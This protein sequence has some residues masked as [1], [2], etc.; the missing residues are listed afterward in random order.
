ML[1]HGCPAGPR[2][3][4][5]SP[6]V[7]GKGGFAPLYSLFLLIVCTA[8]SAV[9]RS[10]FLCAS[11]TAGEAGR[12]ETPTA[13]LNFSWTSDT[14]EKWEGEL[15]L[16][17]GT[18]TG[19]APLG[20]DRCASVTFYPSEDRKVISISSPEPTAFC[21]A[22]VT[23]AAV[24][25][26][27]LSL[28]FR[29]A[30]GTNSF[31]RTFLLADVSESA[32]RVPL[33]D[34]GHDLVI[35]RAPGD[36]IP[37]SVQ[38]LDRD[39]VPLLPASPSMVFQQGETL[40]I[41]IPV[42]RLPEGAERYEFLA[43]LR[44]TGEG[45]AVW[46]QRKPLDSVAPDAV[47]EF[48][49][50]I[51]QIEGAFDVA[52]ELVLPTA[53]KGKFA[54]PANPFAPGAKE[55]APG[56][57]RVIQ[58][59]ALAPARP[60]SLRAASLEPA[61]MREAL[62]DTID[63]T[64]PSW[65]KIFARRGGAKETATSGQRHAEDLLSLDFL[66]MWQ[67]GELQASVKS[68]ARMGD[69]GQWDSLWQ[70]PLG[71]GHLRPLDSDDPRDASFVRL[72]PSGNPA[73]PSWE[74]YT[75]PI[76]EPGKPHILE[77]EYL[78][79]YP[80]KLGV[81]ILEPS[82]SGGLFPRTLDTE[83]VVGQESLSDQ[84]AHRTL[85]YSLLFWPKTAAPTILLVNRDTQTPAVYGRIRIYRAKDSFTAM[86]PSAAKGRRSMTA[87]IS[88]PTFC[89]QF[90]AENAPSTAGVV[91]ARDWRA[92][93]QGAER[94]S[95]Y[96]KIS[97]WDSL[98][99]SVMADGS[100]LYPSPLL[101]PNPQFD[102][103]IFLTE[104]N[105]PVRKDVVDYLL[106]QFERENLELTP[107]FSFNA[108]LPVLEAEIRAARRSEGGNPG[109]YY[110]VGAKGEPVS[111]EGRPVYNIL[112]PA[113]QR[114]ILRVLDEFAARYAE[115]PALRD[116]ALDLASDTFVRLP[117]SIYNGLDD[118]TSLRFAR[119][120]HLEERCPEKLRDRLRDF[121][122]ARDDGRF[123]RR[124]SM[125]RDY[126]TEDW[127][128]WRAFTVSRFYRM[129]AHVLANRRPGTRLLLVATQSE[130]DETL[131]AAVAADSETEA[132]ELRALYRR[133]IDMEFIRRTDELRWIRSVPVTGAWRGAGL[134]ADPAD[135]YAG[136]RAGIG[137][138]LFYRDA[139]PL[140][141]PSFDRVSPYHPTVTQVSGSCTYSDYQNL[142]RWAL[143]LAAGDTCSLMDGGE[144]LPMGE[145]ES[146]GRWIAAFRALPAEPFETYTPG[147]A[148]AEE[149]AVSAAEGET[150]PALLNGPVVFRYRK[151]DDGFWGYLVSTAPF[152]CGVTLRMNC[153]PRAETTLYA[154]G[155][156][157]SRPEQ[158]QYGFRW[159]CSLGPYDLVT[160]RID[161][162]ETTVQQFETSLPIDICGEGGRLEEEARSL[163]NR[164][165]IAS[166]GVETPLLNTGFEESLP[167]PD[168]DLVNAGS[169]AKENGSILGLEIPK[170]NLVRNPFAD[171]KAAEGVD[172]GAV[173]P[174]TE[175][176]LPAGWHRFGSPEFTAELD[177][178]N[179]VEGN[180][181]LKM[182]S[183]ESA[184]G[185]IGETFA[186]PATGRLYVDAKFGL[187]ADLPD[188]LPFFV[189][190]TGKRGGET[191]QKRLYV[192]AGLLRRA[193]EM[194]QRGEAPDGKVI[195]VRDSLLFD[196]LPTE[197]TEGFAV[198]FD[199][200]PRGTVWVDDLHLYKLAFDRPE[201]ESIQR[202]ISEIQTAL[203]KKDVASL[204]RRTNS[205]AA[206]MLAANLPADAP[207]MTRLA[208]ADA[209]RESESDPAGPSDTDELEGISAD[210]V[211][212][213]PEKNFFQ[214]LI[215]W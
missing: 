182:T 109:A 79:D 23:A 125:I 158:K 172:G 134:A 93:Q 211:P 21:G 27:R 143:Q 52:L 73:D 108:P 129:A 155:R 87:V 121:M 33:D 92:F 41:R 91:G 59:I 206:A 5:L 10:A 166:D 85:R 28:S 169:D 214:R 114:E 183:R 201:Q 39:G 163:I 165:R 199:L 104:G 3:S 65:W 48:A 101:R 127:I 67:W 207:E 120:T 117:D 24:P 128:R 68:L 157:F 150:A 193:R 32:L 58:G 105:D 141:I 197:E 4:F 204:L 180:S 177:T 6:S 111:K 12:T 89:D 8:V 192:G 198:R 173:I 49:V 45:A 57:R 174:A 170:F 102:S 149:E 112:H 17:Q 43:T 83:L 97:G 96:L 29:S 46:S 76:K 181:S 20:S 81:S 135:P 124:A 61:D 200:L 187:P 144:T 118:E 86:V 25:S 156:E 171:G 190:L 38:H 153:S 1:G 179:Q 160:F 36:R 115:T 148:P 132:A 137:G 184:G 113:V 159:N 95:G 15:R 106:R 164:L 185:I 126:L 63:P 136:L 116:A 122:N 167:E 202:L 146:Q 208:M 147:A 119:E 140:N 9:Y 80:Q 88:R 69:W 212:P 98:L 176:G 191:W 66:E 142:R 62:L 31:S 56:A 196:H 161:D 64:N 78:P 151:D 194:K 123:H 70:R 60:S 90:L 138:V 54:L 145:E 72:V 209:V 154:G 110:L 210:A 14:P 2:K 51:R 11:E 7:W 71:S 195:W 215:P 53:A 133:G 37:V 13:R 162:P 18:F 94:L 205:P 35:E 203:E 100:T 99:L 84:V 139:R 107:L 131:P 178:Q 188:E 55:T 82:V 42:S 30:E 50:P 22:Q 40:L 186:L 152:H 103:G 213:S 175:P 168:F 16:E 77:I 44:P 74:S 47:L 34:A 130:P 19:L 75:V 26:S 189:T